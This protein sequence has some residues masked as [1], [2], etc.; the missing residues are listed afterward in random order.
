MA[1]NKK[2]VYHCSVVDESVQIHLCKKPSGGFRS[3]GEF[4][5]Q[6]DQSECQ[7]VDENELPC[8][9]ELSMFEEE[10]REREE[11]AQQ[12]RESSGNY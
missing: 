6:C 2:R 8:P 9:L 5:V 1:M 12:K 7:Y 11:K 4:F 3:K 10:I